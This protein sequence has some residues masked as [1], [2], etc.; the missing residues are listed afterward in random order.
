MTKTTTTRTTRCS[1]KSMTIMLWMLLQVIFVISMSSSLAEGTSMK[2]SGRGGNAQRLHFRGLKKDKDVNTEAG[3]GMGGMDDAK[4]EDIVD[5]GAA[6][7][8]NAVDPCTSDPCVNGDCQKVETNPDSGNIDFICSCVPGFVGKTCDV[9]DPCISDP[10]Q[11]EGSSCD[12][13]T[14]NDG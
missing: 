5:E 13:M 10:C 14:A 9:E 6:G 2:K 8:R 3:G 4:G 12:S 1:N 11:N 7:T